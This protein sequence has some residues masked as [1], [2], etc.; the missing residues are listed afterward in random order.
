MISVDGQTTH[1]FTGHITDKYGL[2]LVLV[3]PGSPGDVPGTG[4]CA[5]PPPY[6]QQPGHVQ[7]PA[8]WLDARGYWLLDIQRG[9][10][11]HYSGMCVF[12]LY[13]IQAFF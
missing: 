1:L 5:A 13:M 8:P 7:G 6:A 11:A 10:Y 4:E 12:M 2:H 3:L 9:G